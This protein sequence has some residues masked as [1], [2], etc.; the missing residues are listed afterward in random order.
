MPVIDTP[1]VMELHPGEELKLAQAPS[2]PLSSSSSVAFSHSTNALAK[3]QFHALVS[4]VAFV[5]EDANDSGAAT[6]AATVFKPHHKHSV[7]RVT[8]LAHMQPQPQGSPTKHF[9]RTVTLASC[10]FSSNPSPNGDA[11]NVASLSRRGKTGESTLSLPSTATR[12]ESTVQFRS[13][14][15]FHSSGSIQSLS[16]VAE[17]MVATVGSSDS[18]GSVKRY[19]GSRQFGVR[20]HGIQHTFL[21]KEQVLLL[22]QR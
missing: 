18:R 21:T 4:G 20:L 17:D 19:K 11:G 13:P 6:A 9:M 7:I 8:L 12:V 5:E 2:T 3:N 10:N 16:V 1:F 15:L 14:L 22:T